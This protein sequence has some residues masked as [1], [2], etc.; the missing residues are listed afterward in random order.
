[1][2]KAVYK[3]NSSPKD[4]IRKKWVAFAKEIFGDQE[5]DF[6]ILTFPAEAMQDLHLFKDEGLIDW[7]E[8]ESK[9]VDGTPNFRIIKGNV[10]CFEK[11]PKIQRKLSEKLIE[12]KVEADFIPY[13]A[14]NY[15]FIISGKNK[16]F[17][18][19]VVNLDFDGRMQA[20]VKYP[21]DATI[22]SVFEFQ[23]KYSRNFSL[24]LTWPV[25][26]GEDLNEYKT[27]LHDVIEGN[28]NDPAALK[29]KA[30]FEASVGTI[31]KLKYEQKSI[32]GVTKVVI[33]KASQNLYTL[34]KHEFYVYGDEKLSVGGR[35]RIIS[36]LFNFTYEGKA[37]QE[38]I[39][40]A[41]DVVSAMS[42]ITDINK[43][44]P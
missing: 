24:F 7:E 4:F 2:P 13:I 40:Y 17:P 31:D 38:N 14:A 9:S 21:F 30:S 10:R 39:I 28:L 15:S 43:A 12:A 5:R 1:M 32:I 34:N 35:K 19:D 27:L 33:K 42:T 25:A 22:K 37:G 8:A 11:D 16:T 3:H 44:K 6:S 36:L 18:V 20:S 41:K 23:K 29:F 26:E